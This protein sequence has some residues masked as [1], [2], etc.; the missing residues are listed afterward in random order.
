LTNYLFLLRPFEGYIMA[1]MYITEFSSEGVDT[2]GRS[3]PV[4]K[5]LPIAEQRVDVSG[6]SAQSAT[7]NTLT[8]FVRINVDAP[9]GVLFGLNPTA[10]ATS[11]R[12]ATDQTEYFAVQPNSGLKIAGITVA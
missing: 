4:A 9:T 10:L 12:M 11:M 7:L 3:I 1:F 5:Q 8:A 6:V 2:K